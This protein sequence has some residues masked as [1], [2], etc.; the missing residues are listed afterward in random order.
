MPDL[1]YAE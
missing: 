1:D